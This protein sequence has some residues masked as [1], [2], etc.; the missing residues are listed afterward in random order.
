[1]RHVNTCPVPCCDIHAWAPAAEL[2]TRYTPAELAD[3][4]EAVRFHRSDLA[5]I[6]VQ[7]NAAGPGWLLVDGYNRLAAARARKAE[8]ILAEV[9]EYQDER[10]ALI[11]AIQRNA[12]RRHL[13]P[14]EKSRA[15]AKLAELRKP[16]AE[17]VKAR[18]AAGG[19]KGGRPAAGT[20]GKPCSTTVRQG[21]VARKETVRK[22]AGELGVSPGTV[23]AVAKVDRT[24]DAALI[25]AMERG[26]VPVG[27]A[28]KL[29]DLPA[30]QRGAVLRELERSTDGWRKAAV[31]LRA[32]NGD[33][34]VAA[35]VDAAGVLKRGFKN[36]DP[37]KLN[38]AHLAKVADALSMV[39]ALVTRYHTDLSAGPNNEKGGNTCRCVAG[40]HGCGPACDC[41]PVAVL[42][43]VAG[44]RGAFVRSG[45]NEETRIGS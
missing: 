26:E 3:L 33:S 40:T 43:M 17:E 19:A 24:E 2:F 37:G 14:V 36:F 35:C 25:G 10:E 27:R 42:E 5:P 21:S 13:S 29:A 22:A 28:A 23:R 45:A 18:R 16:K 20:G 4:N 44:T 11:D 38:A 15:A 6:V 8:T 30:E 41:K 34:Q 1:M 9:W 31:A 7:A 39:L 32:E 12:K